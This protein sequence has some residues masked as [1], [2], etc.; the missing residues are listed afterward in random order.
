MLLIS[1]EIIKEHPVAGTGAGSYNELMNKTGLFGNLDKGK[2]AH[3]NFVFMAVQFGI[4][5]A[6][7]FSLVLAIMGYYFWERRKRSISGSFSIAGF[8]TLLVFI[9]AGMSAVVLG[10]DLFWLL[11][12]VL[13]VVQ[14]CE[15]E[16]VEADRRRMGQSAIFLCIQVGAKHVKNG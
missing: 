7:L 11:L 9:G 5:G 8:I 4:P 12:G 16:L 6:I 14:R 2:A 13:Y 10:L 3:N 1:L 15:I